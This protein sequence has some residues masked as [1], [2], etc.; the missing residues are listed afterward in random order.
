[1]I[2]SN[3]FDFKILKIFSFLD[4]IL[5]FKLIILTIIIQIIFINI[6]FFT[7]NTSNDLF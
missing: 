6:K 2:L 1:M 7:F 4:K 5:N 3:F